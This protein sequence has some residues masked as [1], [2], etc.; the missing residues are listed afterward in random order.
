M[1]P[2]MDCPRCGQ[3]AV[4][5]AACPRCGVIV[6]KARPRGTAAG[7]PAPAR[8]TSGRPEDPAREPSGGPSGLTI[9][10][11][12][13][14]L[15][16]AGAVASR[17]WDRLHRR[18]ESTAD[19]TR[20][21]PQ[22][23]NAG[24]VPEGPPP[25]LSVPLEVPV[26]NL[27]LPTDQVPDADRGRA[28][29]LVRRLASPAS[30]TAPDVQAAEELLT[31]NPDEH[32]IRDL[33]EAVLLN[34]AARHRRQRQYAPC[35]AYLERARQVQ[36]SSTRP[37]LALLEVSMDSGNWAGAEAAARAVLAIDPRSFDA[38]QGLGFT[39]VRE[40][41]SRE[42]V[43]ALRAA[44]EIRDDENVRAMIERIQK[45]LADERGMAER[46]L[47]HFNVRYDG[48]EH[49]AVG[50]EILRALER[51]YATLA[52]TLD[53]EPTSSIAVILFSRE[54][55]YDAAGVPT[56]AGGNFD[57]NDG[58]IRI[59][60]RGLTT[61]LN[62]HMDGTLL[63]ELTHAFVYDR[64]RGV[65][66]GLLHEGLAQYME[67]KRIDSMLTR[68]QVVLLA[69]GRIGGVAGYYLSGLSFVEYL[70][71]NRGMGGINDLLKAMGETR[72]VDEAFR[73]VYGTTL[74]GAL[75]QWA[76]RLHQQFGSG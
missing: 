17:Q 29:D 53:Y 62:P 40:D 74:S 26:Q 55:Y 59:P 21:L 37:L 49:E 42:A 38:W 14:L 61:S 32:G 25:S 6:A 9:V 20:P 43:E 8:V 33:L 5:E 24:R 48:E 52:G 63:H 60:I 72:S 39:L 69:D 75:E 73:Q 3:P 7:A 35:I 44:L 4:T 70:V 51:H 11:A 36:P 50:R 23:G 71:A 34:A 57:Q 30:M 47:A 68:D 10:V 28:D 15:V 16:V 2:P 19:P 12:A 1:N 76:R 22:S 64:T 58:R 56:W 27:R 46:H 13:A 65:A 31:R 67:G 18:R 66:P 54:A 41:R 45:T